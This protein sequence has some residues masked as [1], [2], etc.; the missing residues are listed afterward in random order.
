MMSVNPLNRRPSRILRGIDS[1]AV[2]P[3]IAFME[4][5]WKMILAV[6][7]SIVLFW[8]M[9]MLALIISKFHTFT[10]TN[11]IAYIAFHIICL[12]LEHLNVEGV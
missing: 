7:N 10:Q 6:I 9:K 3:G 11:F 5:K 12:R 1:Y 2:A 4:P 8:F